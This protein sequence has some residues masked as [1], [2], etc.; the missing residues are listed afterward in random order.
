MCSDHTTHFIYFSFLI[1]YEDNS[2]NSSSNM[3]T[4]INPQEIPS[5]PN[6]KDFRVIL[7]GRNR[8]LFIS[9]WDGPFCKDKLLTLLDKGNP[10]GI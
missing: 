6:S 10:F 7:S 4:M 8:Y 2:V 9:T 5:Q 3:Q 1:Q